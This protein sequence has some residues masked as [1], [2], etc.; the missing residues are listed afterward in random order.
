MFDQNDSIG[1]AVYGLIGMFCIAVI[2][3]IVFGV[4]YVTSDPK[5]EAVK[6]GWME[7]GGRVYIVKPAPTDWRIIDG[8]PARVAPTSNEGE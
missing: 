6:R 4:L 2:I 3:G 1:K 5:G 8:E 7:H